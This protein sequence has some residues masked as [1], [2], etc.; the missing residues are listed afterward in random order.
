M[1]ME[2]AW[3]SEMVVSYC[4]AT[5]CH[6]PEDLNL[7]YGIVLMYGDIN[8]IILN[9]SYLELSTMAFKSNLKIICILL[10]EYVVRAIL[11]TKYRHFY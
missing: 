7:K 11:Y 1:E 9:Y 3:I 10:T 5:Q 6:N 4:S 8:K 2:A